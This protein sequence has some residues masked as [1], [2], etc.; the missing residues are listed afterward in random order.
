MIPDLSVR[1]TRVKLTV[2]RPTRPGEMMGRARVS[3]LVLA[4]SLILSI[5][6]R[7]SPV[8]GE[9][10]KKHVVV[11]QESNASDVGADALRRGGNAIDAAVATAF[12][13]AVTLPEAGNLGG[14]GFIV[15]YL[16]ESRE[17]VTVDFRETAPRASD[18]G[19]Y[20]DDKG[21]LS[22]E[23]RKGA[24]AAGVPGTV[25]GLGLAHA[26][27]GKLPWADLIKPA[28]KLARDGFVISDDLARS[29]NAQLTL[30]KTE[31]NKD[32]RTNPTP[33]DGQLAEF[34]ESVAVFAKPDGTPWK[35]GDRLVQ[36]DL[37]ATLARIGAGGPDE[38]YSGE[39]AKRIADY[40]AAHS[41]RIT[42]ED[43]AAY[44]ARVRPP[45]HTTF[46]GAEVYGIG[47]PSS[48]GIVLCE[49][50]NILER[51]DLKADGPGSPRTLHRVAE[52][53]RRAFYTRATRIG[54]PDFANVDSSELTSK[55][56]ADELAK[57]I[58]DQATPSQKLAPFPIIGAEGTQTTH[59]ST[60][61][62]MGNAVALTYT[63]EQSYGAKCVVSG[64]GFLLNDEMGDFNLIPGRTDT[65]GRIGTPPNLIA[66]G[67]RM[68]SSQTP[69]I[70][71]KE[72][73]VAV[74]T[75]SPGGRTIPNTTAWVVLNCLEFGLDPC[76]AVDAPRTHHQWFPDRLVIERRFPDEASIEALRR[77]G[78][79]VV[80]STVQGN[81][82]SIMVDFKTG[83]KHGV[84]DR[85]RTT[86][87]A[88]GD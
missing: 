42:L 47:P 20:L 30:A 81:A 61:D 37:G 87:K 1:D 83:L 25:R 73:K 79:H 3:V 53:M 14:G 59:L 9:P 11:A 65:A 39:T 76:A 68:L 45:V 71:L 10:F 33:D 58:G 46:R 41:G 8:L 86:T 60:I 75:G 6:I 16:A 19:M 12:A 23:C 78:H 64:A 17:V 18:P 38:F 43:L 27:W 77:M 54:D 88:S 80:R 34:P 29:L 55:P 13:L 22:P 74:V 69:T 7:P 84:A 51:Y 49:I 56:Y 52:A 26:Q 21:R 24:W 40:M 32:L 35:A 63:L 62:G 5:G 36:T 48:G 57:S 66:A 2:G 50:L 31:D 15:A 85:R 28:V 67:K 44:Q 72:G 70:V 4:S 82:N